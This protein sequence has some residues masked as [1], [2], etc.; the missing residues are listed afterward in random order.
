MLKRKVEL[1]ESQAA[2][3]AEFAR[4]GGLLLPKSDDLRV[5]CSELVKLKLL[6]PQ[7]MVDSNSPAKH[8]R[9]TVAYQITG[10]GHKAAAKLRATD[11]IE[12]AL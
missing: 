7:P 1:T 9:L 10:D 12:K 3:L 5:T 11:V 2:L 6:R 8:L 4:H